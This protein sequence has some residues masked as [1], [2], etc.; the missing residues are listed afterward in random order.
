MSQGSRKSLA[1]DNYDDRMKIM[2]QNQ[3]RDSKAYLYRLPNEEIREEET[4]AEEE[5]N[6]SSDMSSSRN[7][8]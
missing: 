5:L 4:F 2:S 8:S 3:N 1:W 6:S 7:S